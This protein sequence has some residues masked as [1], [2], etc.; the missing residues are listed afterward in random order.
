MSWSSGTYS[1]F[2]QAQVA[3]ADSVLVLAWRWC[4]FGHCRIRD[5][6]CREYPASTSCAAAIGK[7]RPRRQATTPTVI[8]QEFALRNFAP[9]VAQALNL[10]QARD[11]DQH[12]LLLN[13]GRHQLP[14]L[15]ILGHFETLHS[16]R[17]GLVGN[18]CERQRPC[19]SH[20][21]DLQR[22]RLLPDSARYRTRPR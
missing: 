4:R 21:F 8:I 2:W 16:M 14:G 11:I 15:P 13:S 6:C 12:K 3:A 20:K 9:S 22:L 5:L 7:E 18:S 10:R 17:S 19:C 1:C